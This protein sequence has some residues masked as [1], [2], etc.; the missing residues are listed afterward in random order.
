MEGQAKN[1]A[2]GEPGQEYFG[3]AQGALDAS[4]EPCWGRDAAPRPP[5]CDQDGPDVS[6]GMHESADLV[7]DRARI[8]D[9]TGNDA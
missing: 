4:W 6:Q 5:S 3:R 7:G 1:G 9:R 2:P 8:R